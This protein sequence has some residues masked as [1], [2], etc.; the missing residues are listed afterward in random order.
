MEVEALSRHDLSVDLVRAAS[1][2]ESFPKDWIPTKIARA[3]DDYARFLALARKHPRMALAPTR[4]IDL[5]WHL[6]MLHPVAYS[7][8]CK[9]LIGYVLDHDGGFCTGSA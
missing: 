7:A 3:A 4:D 8:D 9:R 1:R 6:H 5:M 2:S